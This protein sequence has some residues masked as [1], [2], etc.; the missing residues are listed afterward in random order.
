MPIVYGT[1]FIKLSLFIHTIVWPFSYSVHGYNGLCEFV[2]NLNPV[3]R[4]S[5]N[6]IGLWAIEF[7]FTSIF[8]DFSTVFGVIL[9]CGFS[10]VLHGMWH[11]IKVMLA[12]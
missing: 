7:N 1:E 2:F 11:G 9:A 3:Y 4:P 10:F 12:W 8:E 5:I 6:A